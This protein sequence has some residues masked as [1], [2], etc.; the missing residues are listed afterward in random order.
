MESLTLEQ[1]YYI[2]ELV[3]SLAV[4]MS[5]IYVAIQIRQNT[6]IV[7]L[8]SAQNLSHE[9]R[10]SLALLASDAG[11]SDIHLRAMQN[12]DSLAP[13]EKFRFYI[14]LNNVFRVYESAHY[15]NSKRTV[16]PSVWTGIVGN[17]KAT[18]STSGYLAFWQER[19]SIFNKEFQDFY[20]TEVIGN[21]DVLAAFK[22]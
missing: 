1:A 10:E 7:K 20:D 14:F 18:K 2:S 12:I 13:A 22:K 17:M 4:I 16:D 11:L 8:N 19:K 6:Q 21:P 9:L 5:L 3:A 15:Q